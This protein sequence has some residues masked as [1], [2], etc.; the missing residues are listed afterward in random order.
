MS[1]NRYTILSLF[2]LLI[3]CTNP[4]T[5]R[6]VEPP[7]DKT[8]SD[9]FDQPTSSEIVM[10]NL[11]FALE[12]MNSENYIKC[13]VD[14]SQTTDYP[15]VFQPDQN[16]DYIKFSGW[17]LTDERNYINKIFNSSKNI[18]FTYLDNPQPQPI[19]SA[20]NLAETPYFRYELTVDNGE[21]AVYQGKARMRLV[22]NDQTLWSIYYWEDTRDDTQNPNTWS[23]LKANNRF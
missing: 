20:I 13:F 16:I 4:F 6:D 22:Q 14:S 17:Q 15:F 10:S 7:G 23:L 3:S 11:R 9:I 21:T 2:A 12:Q 1:K 19:A 5:T 8:Q 18:V